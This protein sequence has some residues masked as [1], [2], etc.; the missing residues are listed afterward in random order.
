M[1][2][3]QLLRLRDELSGR[4]VAIVRSV[5]ELRLMTARQVET[6]YFPAE[7]HATALTAARTSRR[8]LE[9]LVAQ[10]LLCR[11]SRR[12]G[13]LR[14]GS[15][16]YIYGVGPVA[17]RLLALDTARPRFREPSATF[18]DHCL[19]VTQLVVDLTRAS[20]RDDVG[21]WDLQAEPACWRQFST[22]AGRQWLR[23][24]LFTTVEVGDYE[25][26]WFI[27]VDRSTEHLAAIQRKCQTYLAY[28]QCGLEQA[29]HD[30]FPRVVWAAIDSNRARRLTDVLSAKTWPP[31]LFH[32]VEQDDAVAMLLG[33]GA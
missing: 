10:R 11:L 4:D 26:R 23:P 30:V 22:L 13:G 32:V 16:S 17:H 18:V 14:A 2:R 21:L 28:Y 20:R 6:L 12:V 29:A 19:A 27:E 5:A 31:G 33:G 8:V 24:D 25:H 9:R 15:A 3:P 1:S 7:A